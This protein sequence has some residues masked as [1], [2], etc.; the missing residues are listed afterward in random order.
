M[1]ALNAQRLHR[2]SGKW[3]LETGDSKLGSFKVSIIDFHRQLKDREMAE[4]EL[5]EYIGHLKVPVHSI[6]YED[7]H[8][9]LSE[10]MCSLYEF[11]DVPGRNV[12]SKYQKATSDDLRLVLTNFDKLQDSFKNTKYYQMFE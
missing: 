4:K 11:L 6:D 9:N 7:L 10:V 5:R 3:N 1:S 8:F 2:S 12:N